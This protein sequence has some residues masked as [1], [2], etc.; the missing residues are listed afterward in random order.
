M[1]GVATKYLVWI[2]WA[3][4]GWWLLAWGLAFAADSAVGLTVFGLLAGAVIGHLVLRP[5]WRWLRTG[6]TPE[7]VALILPFMRKG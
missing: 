2:G 5:G 7:V 4:L 6:E 3:L 1:L